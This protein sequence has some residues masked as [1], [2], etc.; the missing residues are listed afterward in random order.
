MTDNNLIGYFDY[1]AAT[2]VSDASLRAM[3]TYYQADFYNPSALYLASRAVK[4][5]REKARHGVAQ[6]IGARPSEIIFTAGGTEANNLAIKGVLASFDGPSEVVTTAI[7]HDSVLAPCQAVTHKLTSVDQKG[8][9]NSQNLAKNISDQTVLVSVGF[10]NNEIGT[11]QPIK[12][13]ATLINDIKA[14]RKQRGIALPLYFHID[15]CQAV[16]Y[17]DISVDRLGVDLMTI[18]S[19]KIYGPKQVGALFVKAG[20]RISP[21]IVGGGQENNLR[22]GT[23]NM[24]GIVGFATALKAAVK[25]HKSEALRLS[26]IREASI[27][28]LK[29]QIP[30]IVIN[31]PSSNKRIANNIHFTVAGIDNEYFLMQL[32]ELGFQVATGS[33]C[34]ASSGEASH[35]LRAIGLTDAQAHSSIRVSMGKFTTKDSADNLVAAIK[36]LTD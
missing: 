30:K 33:A 4:I 35:V 27:K 17:L 13:L 26:Y 19:S 28:K 1:A 11:I 15:A 32:D 29:L 16:N 25:T 31:G 2:T 6:A 18:N 36:K 24:A 22:S 34:S 7:E 21:I 9:I 5:S 3:E 20:T 14:D 23:E 10:V 8:F 12:Q